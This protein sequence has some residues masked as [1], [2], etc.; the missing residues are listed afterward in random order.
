[1]TASVLA[2]ELSLPMFTVRLDALMSKYMGESARKLRQ[3]FDS[4]NSASTPT[5]SAT[6]TSSSR[7]DGRQSQPDARQNH[8]RP[9]HLGW[10]TRRPA[11]GK[12]WL[13]N[14]D[15]SSASLS[16]RRSRAARSRSS[17]RPTRPGP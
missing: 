4:R 8:G 7:R 11:I 10:G 1:M 3:I 16:T 6:R 5:V 12:P 15:G 17:R 9:R 2:H 14:R 13:K